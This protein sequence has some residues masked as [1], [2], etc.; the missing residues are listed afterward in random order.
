MATSSPTLAPKF[1]APAGETLVRGQWKV[2][3]GIPVLFGVRSFSDFRIC[4]DMLGIYLSYGYTLQLAPFL[5]VSWRSL[6]HDFPVDGHSFCE[7]QKPWIS[8]VVQLEHAGTCWNTTESI[9][10]SEQKRVPFGMMDQLVYKPLERLCIYMISV[11]MDHI[12]RYIAWYCNLNI[13]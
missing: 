1:W 11:F 7:R 8:G 5:F 6:G 4:M 13:P 9:R 10:F 12:N 2:Y 3:H